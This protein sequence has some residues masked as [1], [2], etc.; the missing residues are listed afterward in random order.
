MPELGPLNT[1]SMG[2]ALI[3]SRKAMFASVS[4]RM[5]AA[6]VANQQNLTTSLKGGDVCIA[7]FWL[8][9]VVAIPI[10]RVPAWENA[11]GTM[12]RCEAFIDGT[13]DPKGRGS[14]ERNPFVATR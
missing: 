13:H 9:L 1:T 8:P 5:H 12:N 14:P 10:V 2:V 4:R 11:L 7:V 6:V 3:V